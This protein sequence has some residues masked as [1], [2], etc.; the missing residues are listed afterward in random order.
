MLDIATIGLKVIL[1]KKNVHVFHIL[2]RYTTRS[3]NAIEL[4]EPCFVLYIL[5]VVPE[6][7]KVKS[8]ACRMIL[9]SFL[10]FLKLDLEVKSHAHL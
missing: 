2:M 9:L 5:F 3:T 6:I 8:L 4:T 7:H 10:C 1:I